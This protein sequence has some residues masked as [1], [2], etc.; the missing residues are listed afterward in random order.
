MTD[1]AKV[2]W[3]GGDSSGRNR[4]FDKSMQLVCTRNGRVGYVGEH[5]MLDA[6]PVIPL[7]RRM[8]KTTYKRLH[9]KQ[10]PDKQAIPDSAVTNIFENCWS[11]PPMVAKATDL[12]TTAKV[13][14]AKLTGDYELQVQVFQGYGKK[15]LKHAG[16]ICHDF[17]QMAMQLAAYR[18][19]KK[20]VATYEAA[21]TRTFLHGRTE[22]IRPVSP[23]S[24]AFIECMGLKPS[25]DPASRE[26][27]LALLKQAASVHDE[28][29]HKASKGLGVDRHFFGLSSMK[30]NGEKEP[31]L[32]SHPLYLRSK[33]WQLSTSSVIFAPGF[34]PVVDDGMGIG[35][36]VAADSCM[37]T[38][39]GRKENQHVKQYCDLLEEALTEMGHLVES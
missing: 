9:K 1:A 8:L 6:A 29:Q 23:E 10:E 18:L 32:F 38:C 37:F 28:Y 20:Q 2:F 5:S 17:V 39:T 7:I 30:R 21:S 4:W 27:K 13:H 22:T 15:F 3:Y 33:H 11:S 24:Q 34:G 16:F 35:Y 12:T 25:D 31:S 19:Y 26:E 14:H 36:Q